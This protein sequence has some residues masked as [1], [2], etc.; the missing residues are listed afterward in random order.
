MHRKFQNIIDKKIFLI[1]Y[2]IYFYNNVLYKTFRISNKKN[3]RK[4][5]FFLNPVRYLFYG[6]R[7]TPPLLRFLQ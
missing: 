2:D 7:H 5:S 1:V 3:L 4:S 6:V